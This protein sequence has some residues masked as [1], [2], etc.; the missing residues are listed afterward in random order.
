M[1]PLLWLMS[2]PAEAVAVQRRIC[3][4]VDIALTLPD[5][6]DRWTDDTVDK[7]AR[8]FEVTV[9]TA[10]ALPVQVYDVYTDGGGAHVGCTPVL[11][12]QSGAVYSATA[13]SEAEISGNHVSSL[14]G[15]YPATA[16]LYSTFVPSTTVGPIDMYPAPL[17]GNTDERWNALAIVTYGLYLYDGGVTG[18]DLDIRLGDDAHYDG[19]VNVLYLLDSRRKFLVAHELGHFVTEQIAGD[20]GL[21]E[22]YSAPGDGCAGAVNFKGDGTVP[23]HS[24]LT[25]EYQSS[26]AVEGMANFYS[27]LVWNERYHGAD[28]EIATWK[29]LD[30]DNSGASPPG[31][32]WDALV[33]EG[34][35]CIGDPWSA[36]GDFVSDHDWL[37]DLIAAADYDDVDDTGC[38]GTH[39]NRSTD[40]DWLRWGWD[41]VTVQDVAVQ[42]LWDVWAAASPSDWNATDAG[43]TE[44]L[45]IARIYGAVQA[46]NNQSMIDA[47]DASRHHGLDY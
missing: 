23:S 20:V 32:P 3:L 7:P 1:S 4:T 2:P 27:A 19:S 18:A 13:T 35:P 21:V 36:P 25:K 30:W 45:P 40:Y 28:C 15:V 47:F 8:G 37:A 14:D 31:E 43:A 17:P 26:A 24:F 34:V 44:D 46:T 10:G 6:G 11:T 42:A 29:P 38:V 16:L 39:L 9:D 41:M 33:N 12:L 22:D 5:R